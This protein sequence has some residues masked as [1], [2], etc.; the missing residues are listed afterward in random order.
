MSASA[1]EVAQTILSQFRQM[2]MMIGGRKFASLSSDSSFQ[3]VEVAHV[4]GLQVDL[5]SPRGTRVLFLLTP[6]D[7]YTLVFGVI[8]RSKGVPTWSVK[9]II[10]GIYVDQIE[11]AFGNYTGMSTRF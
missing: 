3:D 1:Q 2:F 9:K 8:R 5:P 6:L 4:G 10:E 11:E 7:T